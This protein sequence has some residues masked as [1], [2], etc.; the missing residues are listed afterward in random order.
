MKESE[1]LVA[2]VNGFEKRK[3]KN[4]FLFLDNIIIE[5]IILFR[6]DESNSY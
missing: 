5:K 3:N 6:F 1:F 4:F 2:I